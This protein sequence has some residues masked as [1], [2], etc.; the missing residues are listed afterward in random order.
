MPEHIAFA[1]DFN[2]PASDGPTLTE[3]TQ[4][5]SEAAVANPGV[6]HPDAQIV[7]YSVSPRTMTV[8]M[9]GTTKAPSPAVV[10]KIDAA[11]IARLSRITSLKSKG[12]PDL[13]IEVGAADLT[14]I[15][16]TIKGDFAIA[17][18][19][20]LR[21][22]VVDRSF[23]FRIDSDLLARIGERFD[24]PMTF[25]FDAE[26]DTLRW[27]E[28][29]REGSF[30]KVV[31]SAKPR[32]IGNVAQLS[33]LAT[34]PV[35]TLAEAVRYSAMFASQA[36]RE[37]NRHDGLRI[38]SGSATSGC[39][40]AGAKYIS[41]A[42]PDDLD[43]VL[44]LQSAGNL[45]TVLAKLSGP[46]DI[47]VTDTS[48]YLKTRDTSISW[49][50]GGDWPA[51]FDEAFERPAKSSIT[52]STEDLLSAVVALSIAMK[53][54]EIRIERGEN[55][56]GRLVL[57][58]QSISA[59]GSSAISPWSQVSELPKNIWTFSLDVANLLNALTAV[60]TDQ[61][62]LDVLDRGV[63]LRSRAQGYETTALLQGKQLS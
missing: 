58:G 61:V 30:S 41:T 2:P 26:D 29:R 14:C 4:S 13:V 51:S 31:M 47:A 16:T 17:C 45:S 53:E 8:R 33:T 50:K 20:P 52:F 5:Q 49:T 12:A 43:I 56:L 24:G 40:S 19:L 25:T 3:S 35:T 21:D 44:R 22:T 48:V 63:Y 18:T 42:I 11:D 46:V 62:T 15:A 28:D 7:R 37:R 38:G 39:L 55:D 36:L 60:R 32:D 27:R 9:E 1:P 23:A 10:F 34:L 54:V 59:T 6:E 57:A